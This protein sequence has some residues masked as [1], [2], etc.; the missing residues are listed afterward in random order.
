MTELTDAEKLEKL[1]K[2]VVRLEKDIGECKTLIDSIES[3]TFKEPKTPLGEVLKIADEFK[4]ERKSESLIW[5]TFKNNVRANDLIK[6]LRE[7][8]YLIPQKIA[9]KDIRSAVEQI[10]IERYTF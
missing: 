2:I 10:L 4:K 8:G 3:A 6:L 7:N 5:L 1:K 9:K